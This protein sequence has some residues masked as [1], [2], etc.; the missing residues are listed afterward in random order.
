MQ[1][2]DVRSLLLSAAVAAIVGLAVVYGSG[3]IPARQAPA[4]DGPQSANSATGQSA[5]NG[6]ASL[7]SDEIGPLVREYLI[8]NPD[9]LL[10]VQSAL[11][12]RQEAERREMVASVIAERE[13]D[14]FNSSMDIALGNPQGDVTVVEFFDYN[15]SYCKRAHQDM[16]DI[17]A[18]DPNVRFVLKEFPILGPDSLEAHRVSMALRLVAPQHYETFH[19]TLIAGSARADA[20]RALAIAE[21]LGVSPEALTAR[22]DDPAIEAS[23]NEAYELANAL[24]ISGTPSYVLR[25]DTVFGAQGAEVLEQKIA[26]LRT[27]D[28]ANC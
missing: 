22:L 18:N 21:E 8:N 27:C 2:I 10:E 11:E 7:D 14:L 17:I 28:S 16:V 12:L 26:N 13:D 19:N 23:I 15:C 20:A 3:Q 4:Q 5:G 25:D 9:V 6:I 1:G 24:G